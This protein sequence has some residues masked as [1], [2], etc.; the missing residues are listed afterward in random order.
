MPDITMHP[1]KS[2]NV[3]A[4][5]HD[6][7]NLIVDFLNGRAYRYLGV[8]E[9]ILMDGLGAISVGKWLNTAIKPVYAAEAL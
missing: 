4:I 6:G 5:G 7:E 8:P 9:S 3:K 1:V 2:S